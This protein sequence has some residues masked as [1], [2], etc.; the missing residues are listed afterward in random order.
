M[1][2]GGRRHTQY[3]NDGDN[4][5]FSGSVDNLT[6]KLSADLRKQ[7]RLL[8][9]YPFLSQQWFGMLDN[10]HHI[11]NV[12]KMEEQQ[13]NRRSSQQEAGSL[14]DREEFTVRIM[15]EELKLNLCLRMLAEYKEIRRH[16]GKFHQLITTKSREYNWQPDSVLQSMTLFEQNMGTLLACCFN[17]VETFQTLD[18]GVFTQH[19]S[20][21]LSHANDEQTL[22]TLSPDTICTLQ[23]TLVIQY[24]QCLGTHL[25]SLDEDA[26]VGMLAQHGTIAHIINTIFENHTL[27][28][29][30]LSQRGCHFLS[31]VMDA[32][33]FSAN[34]RQLI[35]ESYL[36]ERLVAFKELLLKDYV[37]DFSA[38]K[39][40]QHLLDYVSKLERQGLRAAEVGSPRPSA[41]VATD[42][43]SAA[44]FAPI[45]NSSSRPARGSG[46]GGNPGNISV[47]NSNGEAPLASPSSPTT[48]RAKLNR[49]MNR[50][51]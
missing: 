15:I 32:D 39:Q 20:D 23:E 38:R 44:R 41:N 33:S 37:N 48:V 8:H 18:L 5:N 22:K 10:L 51:F 12:A 42:A 7:I 3:A 14:W 31:S 29:P 45:G 16:E 19:C 28:G 40:V 1:F 30:V 9:N 24:L 13:P 47:N 35:P 2:L 50:Y 46:G 36:N 25:E 49:F 21:V 27:L 6:K 34:S 17:S 11:T 43:R 4:G 26:V